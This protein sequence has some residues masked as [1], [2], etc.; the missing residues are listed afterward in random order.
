MPSKDILLHSSL[1]VVIG[2][3]NPM[4]NVHCLDISL[5]I[6]QSFEMESF[7]PFCLSHSLQYIST[8]P[9]SVGLNEDKKENPTVHII[10]KLSLKSQFFQILSSVTHRNLPRKFPFPYQQSFFI[11]PEHLILTYICYIVYTND[12]ER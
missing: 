8:I 7:L 9:S 10:Y 2:G 11:H 3:K 12:L 4:S 5:H 1:S 6:L